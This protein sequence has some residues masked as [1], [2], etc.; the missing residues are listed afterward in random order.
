[1]LLAGIEGVTL[2]AVPWDNVVLHYI[3]PV[4]MLIDFLIDRP[5]RKIPFKKSL[6][7]LLFPII[8]VAYSLIRGTMIGWYPYPFLNPSLKG[9]GAVGLTVLGLLILA[10]LL[11]WIITKLPS[12]RKTT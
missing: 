1:V 7:W 6:L 11:I 8:Y 9:Y 10:L 5:E 4:A 2:T 12:K 3:M